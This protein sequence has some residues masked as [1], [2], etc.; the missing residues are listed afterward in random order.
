MLSTDVP[1]TDDP[2][3]FL[4]VQGICI[5]Y[6]ET[7]VCC[8]YYLNSALYMPP[9]ALFIQTCLLIVFEKILRTVIGQFSGYISNFLSTCLDKGPLLWL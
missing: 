5:Q 4:Q 6:C 7:E 3:L 9:A 8:K 2:S 1:F